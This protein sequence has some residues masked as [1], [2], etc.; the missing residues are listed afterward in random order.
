VAEWAAE[1]GSDEANA[2]VLRN[3]ERCVEVWAETVVVGTLLALRIARLL[4]A[5]ELEP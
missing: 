2:W 5:D 3:G 1:A 4:N